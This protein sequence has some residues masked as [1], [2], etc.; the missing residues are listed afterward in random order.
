M[1]ENFTIPIVFPSN[2]TFQDTKKIKK[3]PLRRINRNVDLWDMLEFVFCHVIW[4]FR[5]FG[6]RSKLIDWLFAAWHLLKFSHIFLFSCL[7][8][9]SSWMGKCDDWFKDF[10]FL[11]VNV[12]WTFGCAK[13][14][15]LACR[16]ADIYRGIVNKIF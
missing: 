2:G 9:C 1:K 14:V 11:F 7:N 13:R 5:V 6:C 3:N 8:T 15:G 16:Y 12:S 4:R 10:R